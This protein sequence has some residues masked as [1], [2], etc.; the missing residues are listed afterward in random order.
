MIISN[1]KSVIVSPS[2]DTRYRLKV[3]T[4]GGQV[5]YNDILVTRFNYATGNLEN[6]DGEVVLEQ[7]EAL[8][9]TWVPTGSVIVT[10]E[11][12]KGSHTYA[13]AKTLTTNG[14]IIFQTDVH[15]P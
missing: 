11:D 14:G 5:A 2:E 7:N 10:N 12:Y 15:V 8:S 6:S 3:E 9:D 13:N 4:E 1:E